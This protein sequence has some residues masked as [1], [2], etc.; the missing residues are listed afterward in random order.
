MIVDW[1]SL[2]GP[3]GLV[4]RICSEI[5]IGKNILLSVP[6][7]FPDG[8]RKAVRESRDLRDLHWHSLTVPVSDHRH[9][10]DWLW[11]EFVFADDH[12]G[13]VRSVEQL[14]AR[15]ELSGMVVWVDGLGPSCAGTL[16]AFL[17][18]F[19]QAMN[20][21][22]V[23]M[24]FQLCCVVPLSSAGSF[25][26]NVCCAVI[27]STS[28]VGT[29]DALTYATTLIGEKAFDNLEAQ[30]AASVLANLALWDEELATAL[31][32]E[33]LETILSP[34][35]WLKEWG[36]ANG[37]NAELTS[38][39]L[40]HSGLLA[41]FEGQP[42]LHSA[43]AAMRGETSEV[44][45]RVWRGQAGVLLP[46]IEER[47]RELLEYLGKLIVLP[48]RTRFGEISDLNDLEIGHLYSMFGHGYRI[49]SDAQALIRVLREMRN[50]LAHFNPI[51]CGL[52][53]CREIR[54]FRSI[55]R[56]GQRP[57][58]M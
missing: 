19:S 54:I 16:P 36:R 53:A 24:R 48:Y 39:E 15:D 38:N 52:I 21:I 10:L 33:P 22:A 6:D 14:L 5:R 9:P 55:L 30:V 37:W 11:E 35:E 27:D 1:W 26:A 49:D 51:D 32:R 43:I 46:F 7:R 29:I 47:R 42:K 2:P 50:K 23:F 4:A 57:E 25:S 31:S 8:L 41:I 40:R 20:G 12:P 44:S 58:K 56:G 3:Q 17:E 28:Y 45:A 34:L 18:R 13:H